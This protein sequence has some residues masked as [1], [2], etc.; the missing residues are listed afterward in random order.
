MIAPTVL[1][2]LPGRQPTTTASIVRMRLIFTMPTR[3]AG[4]VGP[5]GLLRD[6]A[7]L[8]QQ[9][10]AGAGGRVGDGRQLDGAGLA[11]ARDQG[12]ERRAA[13]GVGQLEQHLV[14]AREEVERD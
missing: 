6:H 2:A 4:T 8:V 11:E 10:V 7:L 12:L 3:Y 1:S 13:F 5:R 14:L 9:P